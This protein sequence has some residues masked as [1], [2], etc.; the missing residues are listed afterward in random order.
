MMKKNKENKERKPFFFTTEETGVCKQVKIKHKALLSTIILG[1][2]LVLLG[3]F[4]MTGC[5]KKDNGST[6]TTK[7]TE[8]KVY[9]FDETFNMFQDTRNI[10]SNVIKSQADESNY[11]EYG[12]SIIW[13]SKYKVKIKKISYSVGN[14]STDDKTVYKIQNN[15]N[16]LNSDIDTWKVYHTVDSSY[17]KFIV[18]PNETLDV[19]ATYD[20]FIV[21]KG[22]NWSM[23]FLKYSKCANFYNFKVEFEVIE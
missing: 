15:G 19:V 23:T 8:K 18:A 11:I 20:N 14:T 17:E 12:N 13:T 1:I 7:T 6:T 22:Q 2:I 3:L 16:W 9:T 10:Y 5:K 21:N 4:G